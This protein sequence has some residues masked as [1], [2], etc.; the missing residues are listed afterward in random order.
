MT[1]SSATLFANLSFLKG[2]GDQ[3]IL[4]IK[5]ILNDDINADST[6]ELL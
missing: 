3:V 4:E 5:A 2:H 1:F 6:E